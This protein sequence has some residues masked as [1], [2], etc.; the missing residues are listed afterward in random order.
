MVTAFLQAAF[1]WIVM[2]FFVAVSCSYI[3]KK[4]K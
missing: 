1:P 3:S 2:G 4:E